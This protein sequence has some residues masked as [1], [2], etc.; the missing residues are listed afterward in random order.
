MKHSIFKAGSIKA[1]PVGTCVEY[2]A[3]IPE[4]I[5]QNIDT[6]MIITVDKDGKFLTPTAEGLK[7]VD[8]LILAEMPKC[9]YMRIK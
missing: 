2:S 6:G 9:T 5:Y 7:E 8:E 3:L 4:C 1:Q